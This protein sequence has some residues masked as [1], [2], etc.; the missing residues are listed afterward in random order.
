MGKPKA[1]PAVVKLKADRVGYADDVE[2]IPADDFLLRFGN[3]ETAKLQIQKP[4]DL[5][6]LLNSWAIHNN[7][8]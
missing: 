7:D 8:S 2:V 3:V 1:F 6:E 5:Q 4:L